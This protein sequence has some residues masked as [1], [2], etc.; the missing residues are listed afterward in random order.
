MTGDGLPA[1]PGP[2][3]GAKPELRASDEDRERVVERLRVAAGDGRLT[4]AELDERLGAALTARTSRELAALTADLPEAGGIAAR[5]KDV[6]RLDYKAG[7][8]RG[9]AGG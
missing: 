4:A 9:A 3:G 2:G 7:M 5:A 6:V 8:Q 1:A